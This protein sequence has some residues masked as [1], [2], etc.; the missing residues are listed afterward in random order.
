M[1][2]IADQ[3]MNSASRRWEC[4][5]DT[6]VLPSFDSLRE[7]S[8]IHKKSPEHFCPGLSLWLSVMARSKFSTG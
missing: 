5:L 2:M 8:G 1:L 3:F 6:F 7:S 4:E